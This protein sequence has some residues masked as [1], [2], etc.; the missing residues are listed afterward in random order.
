MNNQPLD[1][2]VEALLEGD[3]TRAVAEASGLRN[4]GV[5]NKV[6]IIEGIEKAMGLLDTKRTLE[7][8]N[9]LEIMLVGRAVMGVIKTLYPDLPPAATR[10]TA[11]I[12]GLEGDVHDLGK[13]IVKT[14]MSARGYRIVDCGKD[15][16]VEK[17]VDAA[18]REG[19]AVI[20]IS[21]LITSIIPLVRQVLPLAR[22]R[23]LAKVKVLAG[24][25]AL[26]QATADILNV[27]YVA[28][29]VFDGIH[30]L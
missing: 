26:K 19:A 20:A 23:G 18:V 1:Q 15:C 16:P 14:I 29:S 10:G 6:I 28:D 4:A 11:V 2:L 13:N 17:L 9:L 25:A 22:E 8:F 7:Q 5:D 27:D 12:A 30:F 3:Q 24:G 21:G